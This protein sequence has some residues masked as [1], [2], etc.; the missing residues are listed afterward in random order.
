MRAQHKVVAR[1][2]EDKGSDA[3]HTI[4]LGISLDLE[5]MGYELTRFQGEVDEELVCPICAG[6]LEEPL[7]VRVS[8]YHKLGFGL[9]AT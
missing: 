8:H 1:V 3:E 5:D 4:S 9:S 7:Q 6:V 2:I